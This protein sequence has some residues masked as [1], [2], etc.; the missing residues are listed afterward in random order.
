MKCEAKFNFKKKKYGD[1][2]KI[3]YGVMTPVYDFIFDLSNLPNFQHPGMPD[4]CRT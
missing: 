2:S 4:V 3:N 1:T